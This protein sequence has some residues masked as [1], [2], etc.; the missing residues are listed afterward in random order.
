MTATGAANPNIYI[1]AAFSFEER[2]EKFK[3]AFQLPNECDGIGISQHIGPHPRVFTGQWLEVRN[4]KRV[5]QEPDIEQE[6][7]IVRHTE[8]VSE[9]YQ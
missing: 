8:L 4:E 1:A 2:Y 7:D 9:C 6:V 3:E 5:P